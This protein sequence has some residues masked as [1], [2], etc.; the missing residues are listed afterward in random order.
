MANTKLKDITH[1][2]HPNADIFKYDNKR[3]IVG[4][5]PSEDTV[6]IFKML[7]D[8]LEPRSMHTIHRK[9]IVETALRLSP[10]ATISLCLGL[11]KQLEKNGISINIK[12]K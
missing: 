5:T 12:N 11:I 2:S 6:I 8:D 10:E 9:K 1:K 7:S 3:V 4:T